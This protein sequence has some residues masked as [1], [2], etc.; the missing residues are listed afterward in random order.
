MSLEQ[1][2]EQLKEHIKVLEA[3][4]QRRIRD[5]AE[6]GALLMDVEAKLEKA[7]KKLNPEYISWSGGECPVEEGEVVEIVQ[8]NGEKDQDWAYWFDWGTGNDEYNIVAYRIIE[9]SEK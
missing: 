8:A 7:V 1:E 6:Q 2:N 9:G 4:L 5:F 3:A